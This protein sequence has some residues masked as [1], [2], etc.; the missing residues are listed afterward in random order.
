VSAGTALAV[1][2]R[3]ENLPTIVDHARTWDEQVSLGRELVA[4][5][6]TLDWH[7]RFAIGDLANKA[8]AD[9]DYDTLRAFAED[10]GV[11]YS[12]LR[13]MSATA[14]AFPAG[15]RRTSVSW[16]GHRA[17]SGD[18]DRHALLSK[19]IGEGK[20]TVKA[21]DAMTARA[22]AIASSHARSA[23]AVSRHGAE[24]GNDVEAATAAHHAK[25]SEVFALAE[26]A[27]KGHDADLL[28]YVERRMPAPDAN[29]N[30]TIPVRVSDQPEVDYIP[31]KPRPGAA[32]MGLPCV[33]CGG[34]GLA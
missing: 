1:A 27:D 9:Q 34:T 12:Y 26:E 8:V 10:I 15:T 29:G 28:D 25:V 4:A 32:T 19:A 23:Y 31:P 13:Q 6:D 16:A 21:L 11:E 24:E 30:V 7:L 20:T 33:H 18:P 22:Q 17:L 3:L 5:G 2:N 14:T